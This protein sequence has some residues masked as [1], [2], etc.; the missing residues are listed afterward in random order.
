LTVSRAANT[1]SYTAVRS[2][3]RAALES[4]ACKSRTTSKFIAPTGWDIGELNAAILKQAGY[5]TT[6][7]NERSASGK[8]KVVAKFKVE[9]GIPGV[10]AVGAEVTRDPNK[11][12]QSEVAPVLEL[13]VF[14]VNDIIR[15]L[16]L[17]KFDKFVVLEDFHYLKVETQK[18]FAIALK[19]YHEE[20][21]IYF[22]VVGVWLE[23]GRLVVYN[24]DLTGRL[25]S[26]NADKWSMDELR[27]VINLGAEKLNIEFTPEFKAALL[28]GCFESVYIVQE[29]CYQA[30]I[31]Q[32]INVRKGTLTRIGGGMDVPELIR[33]VVDQQTARYNAFLTHFAF[34]L[35]ANQLEMYKWILYA[36]LKTPVDQLE[37]GLRQRDIRNIITAAHPYGGTLNPGSVTQALKAVA[38]LQVKKE[39]TPIV[40]DYDQTNLNLRVVDRSFLIWL[41][42]QDTNDLLTELD[43]P[44]L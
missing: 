30:C 35:K 6:L 41:N 28:T 37:S 4:I 44:I 39:I 22:I 7:S 19:A 33:F 20:S 14:D 8:N 31:R 42:N 32:N 24:G 36:V 21:D 5:E 38:A 1:L 43:L 3:E 25:I 26:I 12:L 27:S 11:S 34:G 29:V 17:V 9:V 23:E 2:K 40:L 15:A 10:A 18:D 16:K 13:D